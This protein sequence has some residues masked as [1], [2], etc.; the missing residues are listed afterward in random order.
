VFVSDLVKVRYAF[1]RDSDGWPPVSSEDVWGVA[2]SEDMIRVDNI[3]WFVRDVS[4]GD[5]IRVRPLS[6]GLY[7]AVEKIAWSGNCTIRI[8]LLDPGMEMRAGGI[9]E[10]VAKFDTL[11]ADGEILAT[12]NMAAINIP[13]S[14]NVREAKML[15]IEGEGKGW[16]TY[17]EACVGREWLAIDASK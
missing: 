17:E 10:V 13:P 2:V 9:A 7:K 16:W 4:V 11:G 12:Y 15:L 6:A 8:I 5:L 3:P 1:L 14:A